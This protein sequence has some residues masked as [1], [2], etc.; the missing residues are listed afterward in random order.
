MDIKLSDFLKEN[1]ISYRDCKYRISKKNKY[2]DS[3]TYLHW[4]ALPENEK[5]LE[6]LVLSQALAQDMDNRMVYLKNTCVTPV[7][8]DGYGL[9]RPMKSTLI[10]PDKIEKIKTFMINALHNGDLFE[11]EIAID[12]SDFSISLI[13][14][15][16]DYHDTYRHSGY[17]EKERYENFYR[18]SF[19]GFEETVFN[20][21]ENL[22]EIIAK[23]KTLNHFYKWICD[24]VSSRLSAYEW[25]RVPNK[26]FVIDLLYGSVSEVDADKE[27]NDEYDLMYEFKYEDIIYD[28]LNYPDYS[29]IPDYNVDKTAVE[30]N[31]ISAFEDYFDM[32]LYY[33]EY[34]IDDEFM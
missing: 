20:F 11:N 21:I 9:I 14:P 4:F 12:K 25:K 15:E 8:D 17:L 18:F 10:E 32:E 24:K 13:A 3:D 6:Y 34:I 23:R 16:E 33:P 2:P 27:I 30:I 5:G 7:G 26:K 22:E 28:C 31:C 1:K 29:P 19:D